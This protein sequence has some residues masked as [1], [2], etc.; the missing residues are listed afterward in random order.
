MRSR[1]LACLALLS[2]PA[3]IGCGDTGNE[4]FQGGA[5][6]AGEVQACECASGGQGTST[7][8]DDGSGMGECVCPDASVP[9]G[10]AGSG[11][12]DAQPETSSKGGSAGADAGY[13]GAAGKDAG[14]GAVAV[15]GDPCSEK[16]KLACAGHAQKLQ[17]LCDGS[18]WIPNGTCSGAQVCDPR[19]GPTAGSCQDPAAGCAGKSPGATFCEGAVRNICGPDLLTVSSV[20]CASD[21]LCQ[22]GTGDQ[23]AVCLAGQHECEGA[24]LMMCAPDHLKWSFDKACPSQALCDAFNGTCGQAQC[25]LRCFLKC[26][27]HRIS[28]GRI[29]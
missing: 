22:G 16:G 5:C 25:S 24:N 12:K 27:C 23:C 15:L 10:A 19:E 26:V 8:L 21:A 20:I 7:C 18:K 11:G 28:S 6:Q 9:D 29:F 3:L 13:G 1:I 2:L 4:L 17:L 14:A